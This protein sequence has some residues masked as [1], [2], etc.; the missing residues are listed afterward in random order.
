MNFHANLHFLVYFPQLR[1]VS[2]TTHVISGSKIV[3]DS[4]SGYPG[5][6]VGSDEPYFEALPQGCGALGPPILPDA[7][8]N[9]SSRHSAPS[10]PAQCGPCFLDAQDI[11][12]WVED[13]SEDH[14]GLE[15][16]S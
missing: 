14:R 11:P 3:R 7:L 16:I 12:L 4:S 15:G 10:I 2:R 1:E 8:H 9:H 13:Y 6:H 5:S